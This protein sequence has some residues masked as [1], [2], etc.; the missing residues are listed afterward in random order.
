MLFLYGC[1]EQPVSCC[2]IST[3]CHRYSLHHC[4]HRSFHRRNFRRHSCCHHNF[5]RRNFRHRSFHHH[6]CLIHRNNHFHQTYHFRLM[7]RLMYH[8]NHCRLRMYPYC[9]KYPRL[10]LYC[11]DILPPVRCQECSV[12]N[13]YS[14]HSAGLHSWLQPS[15]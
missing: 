14:R 12:R 4:C 8:L 13:L 7:Y 9:L 10:Y 2:T 1:S 5:H 15:R 11:P 3:H 6:N